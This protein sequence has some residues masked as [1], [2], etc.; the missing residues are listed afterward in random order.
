M[1][2]TVIQRTALYFPYI[3]PPE[4]WIK[5]SLLLSDTLSSIV[6]A[7]DHMEGL[8]HVLK[9]LEGEGLYQPAVVRARAGA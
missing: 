2:C 1:I 3:E 7:E 5:Q 6:P 4:P 9:W 8:P